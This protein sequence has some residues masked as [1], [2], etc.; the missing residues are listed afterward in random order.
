MAEITFNSDVHKQAYLEGVQD[1]LRDSIPMKEVSTI[2]TKN[3]EFIH[4]RVGDDDSAEDSDD[5]TYESDDAEYSD[6]KHPIRKEAT[7]SH[8]IRYKDIQREGFDIVQDLSARH[9][10][11]LAES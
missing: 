10:F 6:D 4:S 1:E 8:K 11:A 3:V 2:Q 7:K 9:G 5:G